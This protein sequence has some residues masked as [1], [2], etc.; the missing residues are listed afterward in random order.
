[1]PDPSQSFGGATVHFG[2]K[3]VGTWHAGALIDGGTKDEESSVF[4]LYDKVPMC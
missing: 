4:K 1:M 2:P 3:A